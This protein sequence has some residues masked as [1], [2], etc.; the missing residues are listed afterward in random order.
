MS[1]EVRWEVD[2]LSKSVG[3]PTNNIKIRGEWWRAAIGA[4]CP[5]TGQ[6]IVRILHRMLS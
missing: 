6:Y 5:Y 4:I 3:K 1:A 2:F